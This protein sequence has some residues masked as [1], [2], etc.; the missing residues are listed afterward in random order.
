MKYVDIHSH[1]A[2][3]IDDGMPTMQDAQ[4]A[5]QKAQNDGIIAI[6]ST[7]HVVPG[8]TDMKTLQYIYNR[9]NELSQLAKTYQIQIFHGAEMFMNH[10]FFQAL[11]NKVYLTINASQYMLCEFDVRKDISTIESPEDYFYE[12]QIRNMT[13]ILAHVERYFHKGIDLKRI[14]TWK[15]MGVI[16]QVNRTS[17]FGLHG[18][19]IQKN[20]WELVE[21]GYASIIC[22][23]THTAQGNRVEILSD[24][25]KMVSQRVGIQNAK[26]LLYTNPVHILNNEPVE[27]CTPIQQKKK[28][29]G[30]F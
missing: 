26:C 12:I 30:I 24:I 9:Q 3:D 29:F 22:T 25:E 16:I 2:W 21:K 5:L 1:I 11:E 19:T 14:Q 18:K 6:A 23:D 28:L 20:A 4:I 8:Q 13:P 10:D 7:P 17:L 15:E 27:K